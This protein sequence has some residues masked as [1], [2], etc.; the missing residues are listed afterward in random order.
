MVECCSEIKEKIGTTAAESKCEA[1][2]MACEMQAKL[3]E[4]CCEIKI[5]VDDTL[6]TLDSQRLRDALNTANN[7][8]NLLK[9]T[10]FA[11][12]GPP[13]RTTIPLVKNH[14]NTA[15]QAGP[16]VFVHDS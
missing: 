3:A 11:R 12:R 5:K 16:S 2:K 7:E 15:R 4:C 14:P 1:W 10:E 13:L 6:R 9:V 8:V